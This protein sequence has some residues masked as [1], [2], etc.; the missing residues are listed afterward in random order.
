MYVHKKCFLVDLCKESVTTSSSSADNIEESV[1]IENRETG[2]GVMTENDLGV[3]GDVE[4]RSGFLV[5]KS[6]ISCHQ[7]FIYVPRF[8]KYLIITVH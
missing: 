8:L 4:K 7:I 6:A 2:N 1:D 3:P 5:N